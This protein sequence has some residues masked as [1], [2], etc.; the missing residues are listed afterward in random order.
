MIEK[1]KR[2]ERGQPGNTGQAKERTDRSAQ[3]EDQLTLA[4][5]RFALARGEEAIQKA[6]GKMRAR[7]E[8]QLRQALKS[9]TAAREVSKKTGR[10]EAR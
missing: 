2:M 10:D 9:R 6:R 3:C 8:K 1:E 7:F 5:R 4:L